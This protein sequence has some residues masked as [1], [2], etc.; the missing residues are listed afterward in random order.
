MTVYRLTIADTVEERILDLQ[1]AKRKLAKAAIEGGKAIGKLSMAD[2]MRLFRREAEHEGQHSHGNENVP[3]GPTRVLDQPKSY[4]V[5]PA[6]FWQQSGPGANNYNYGQPV[7]PK[8]YVVPRSEQQQQHYQMPGAFGT[9]AYLPRS[10]VGP[11]MTQPGPST[12]GSAGKTMRQ[13]DP[14]WGRR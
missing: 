3:T 11:N 9:G 12:S 14:V 2:I 4:N 6:S 8:P 1:E 13:E 5:P 7:Q 10:A